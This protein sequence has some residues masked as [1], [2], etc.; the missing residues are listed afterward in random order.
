MIES[1]DDGV[2]PGGERGEL[3]G[4]PGDEGRRQGGVALLLLDHGFAVGG[5]DLGRALGLPRGLQREE[6]GDESE[7]EDADGRDRQPGRQEIEKP[8]HDGLRFFRADLSFL[9]PTVTP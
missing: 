8:A 7:H 6:A 1:P 5:N 4:L 2:G 9:S 3:L